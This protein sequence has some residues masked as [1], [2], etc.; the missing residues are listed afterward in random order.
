M[1]L[2]LLLGTNCTSQPAANLTQ[3]AT[4][5]P[6][7]GAAAPVDASPAS[8]PS[9]VPSPG[10]ATRV[11][12]PVF[13][14]VMENKEYEQVVGSPAAPYFNSLASENMLVDQAY[15][16]T[17]PSLPN[18]LALL[19]GDT[20]GIT[21]DCTDC[22]L[23]QPNLVDALEAHGRSWKAY[24]E[25]LPG[26]CALDA[27][28]GGWRSASAGGYALKHDPFLYFQDI[29]TNPARCNRVVPLTQLDGDLTNE[30]APDFI[31]ITPNLQHDT[32]DAS[33][34]EG[35]AWLAGFVP[36]LLASPAWRTGGL[37]IITWDE[38]TTNAGC[39]GLAA[40]GHIP[41]LLVRASGPHAAHVTEPSTHYSILRTIEDVLRVDRLGQSA[42]PSVVPLV[43][44]HTL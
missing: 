34:A 26:S 44:I 39:C 2:T 7:V 25:D 27:G 10:L 32:H 13:L 21:S 3:S 5:V 19:A 43:D 23:D 40:G 29:R 11:V 28:T 4:A 6:S 16:I 30:H 22:F 38:G 36:R 17:H 14:L 20:F 1:L 24:M 41:T 31:W 37:L 35:D 8:S 12:R 18:Y 9:A 15:A 42:A 33:V